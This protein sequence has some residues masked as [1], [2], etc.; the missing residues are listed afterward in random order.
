[1]DQACGGE[2]DRRHVF[3]DE[4]RTTAH[5]FETALPGARPPG[6]DPG[7]EDR[8]DVIG[9]LL[10]ACCE[11]VGGTGRNGDGERAYSCESFDVGGVLGQSLCQGAS[12]PYVAAIADH[13]HR[14]EG[15]CS[16]RSI[17]IGIFESLHLCSVRGRV[18][19]GRS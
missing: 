7:E 18:G 17:T 12:F 19:G 13:G 14:P 11:L 4:C 8:R 10:H 3:L 16:R 9:E 15:A 2:H 5:L 1:M 6:V